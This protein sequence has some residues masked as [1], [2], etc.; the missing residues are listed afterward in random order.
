MFSGAD[1]RSTEVE[2]REPQLPVFQVCLRCFTIDLV[3]V[4]FNAPPDTIE[5]ISEAVFAANHLTDTDKQNSTGKYK[6]NTNQ[7]K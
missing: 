6:L 3:W 2:T 5:V 1:G 4:E 7:K